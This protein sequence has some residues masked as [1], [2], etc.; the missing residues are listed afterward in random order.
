MPFKNITGCLFSASNFFSEENNGTSPV[1]FHS[2][3]PVRILKFTDISQKIIR[4]VDIQY[5]K[6]AISLMFRLNEEKIS[7]SVTV[8]AIL[9]S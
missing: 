9:K 7:I 1:P 4:L 5:S 3:S 8:P 2:H 6:S